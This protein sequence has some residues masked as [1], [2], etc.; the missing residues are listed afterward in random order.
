MT[1]KNEIRKTGFIMFLIFLIFAS[2][3][4]WKKHL[5]LASFFSLLSLMGLLFLVIPKNMEKIFNLWTNITHAIG[6]FITSVIL[7]IVYYLFFVPYA[8][9]IK[10]LRIDPLKN[11]KGLKSYW[12]EREEKIYTLEQFKD[13]F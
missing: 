1:N 9:I 10:L 12:I 4:F 8:L 6:V 11:P 5:I 13:L 2:I 3:L 7:I